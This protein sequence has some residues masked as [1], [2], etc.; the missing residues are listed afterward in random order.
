M[1]RICC[2]RLCRLVWLVVL[3]VVLPLWWL[4]WLSSKAPSR[5]LLLQ[6]LQ[7]SAPARIAHQ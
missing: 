1:V 6:H 2:V 3:V 5:L 4:S 7:P